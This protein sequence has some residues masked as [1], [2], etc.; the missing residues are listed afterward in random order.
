MKKYWL[1]LLLLLFPASSG[2]AEDLIVDGE[3]VLLGGE[4]TYDAVEI[5]NGGILRVAPYDGSEE[6]GYLHLVADSILIDE[7]S[8]IDAANAGYRGLSNSRGEGP[9]GG[10]GGSSSVDGGGGGGYG[11]KGGFGVL[12]G[13]SSPAAS[14]G[15]PY[16]DPETMEIQM[17]SAGGAAG[18]RDGD[19]GGRGGRGGGAVHL[20]ARRITIAGTI[21]ANGENGGVF[22]NDG[23]GGGAGGGILIDTQ[24][25]EFTG[26]LT[27]NGGNGGSVD[28]GGGGGGGGRIKI[29]YGSGT[30]DGEITAQGGHGDG[31][32]A[33]NDGEAGSIFIFADFDR[34][35]VADDADNC[36]QVSN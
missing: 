12:D 33:N 17:G 2:W 27:A 16:G 15:D 26:T 36:P 9:G 21:T 7:N 11:G 34:D 29:F 28:D 32:G 25:F 30:L 3:E 18:A 31:N 22:N 14:G 20:E 6:T 8:R 35:G 23:A 4:A 5:R 24:A 10:D 19:S 13:S 1:F